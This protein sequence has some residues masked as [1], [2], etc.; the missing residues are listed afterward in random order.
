MVRPAGAR[1]AAEDSLGRAATEVEVVIGQ[2]SRH[3]IAGRLPP[4]DAEAVGGNPAGREPLPGGDTGISMG[5][6]WP[7]SGLAQSPAGH[8]RKAGH[9][10]P[11]RPA[12]GNVNRLPCH[13]FKPGPIRSGVAQMW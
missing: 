6:L 4:A 7:K 5:G 1:L 10:S 8:R 13:N 3:V 2:P 9:L 12:G 11:I